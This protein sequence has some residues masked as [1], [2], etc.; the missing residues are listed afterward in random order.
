MNLS[1]MTIQ[2]LTNLYNA[3]SG[4]SPI[5]KFRSKGEAVRRVKS[6]LRE[7]RTP[8]T[9]DNRVITQIA[10]NP[11]RPGSACYARYALYSPGMTIGEYLAAGGTRADVRWDTK[12]GFIQLAE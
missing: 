5:A 10:D 6:L 9:K 8:I 11:K 2:Q 4:K 3:K 12:Q 7:R 1:K